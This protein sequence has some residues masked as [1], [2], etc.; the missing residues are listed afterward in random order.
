MLIQGH[1][2]VLKNG[3][4]TL[5]MSFV[6]YFNNTIFQQYNISSIK[7]N[8]KCFYEKWVVPENIHTPTMGGIVFFHRL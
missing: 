8:K 3:E 1:L 6:Q 4:N 2:K 5:K 7:I